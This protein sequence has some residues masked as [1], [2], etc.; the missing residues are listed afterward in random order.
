MLPFCSLFH[1]AKSKN[2][3]NPA[4]KVRG[5]GLANWSSR[6]TTLSL[7]IL[8]L[9]LESGV[10]WP[11]WRNVYWRRCAPYTS[12]LPIAL[13]EYTDRRA[14]THFSD[15]VGEWQ[16]Q[17]DIQ[18]AWRISGIA[19]VSSIAIA[20][21]ETVSLSSLRFQVSH[22]T[23]MNHISLWCIPQWSLSPVYMH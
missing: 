20:I 18:I 12:G 15:W 3:F 2:A 23:T 10:A 17:N 1:N 8:P 11:I 19:V 4:F 16:F 13:S 21:S 6:T 22:N 5:R 7:G 14:Y 9:S